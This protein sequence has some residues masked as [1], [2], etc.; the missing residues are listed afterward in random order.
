[1]NFSF[2]DGAPDAIASWACGRRSFEGPPQLHLRAMRFTDVPPTPTV[3]ASRALP[4][5]EAALF[6]V[7]TRAGLR[8]ISYPFENDGAVV[9]DVFPRQGEEE[10]LSSH[11]SVP[12]GYHTEMSFLDYSDAPSDEVY[13]CPEILVFV[14]LRN[15]A[16]TPMETVCITEL[17]RDLR[18]EDA[19]LLCRPIFLNH[20]PASIKEE[21]PATL[22]CVMQT[23]SI[24]SS[25]PAF[26]FDEC[27]T[28]STC[29]ESEKAVAGLRGAIQRTEK[30]VVALEPGD[31]F[32][33]DNR[34]VLHG[35]GAIT[36]SPKGQARWLKRIYTVFAEP[37]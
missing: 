15:Q 8:T 9:R 22:K 30:Q 17:I 11:G 10:T 34:S 7:I 18:P 23:R 25:V 29:G 28:A 26:Q 21:R 35:R 36:S 33:I 1:M 12:L 19:E 3:E 24:R 2:A 20:P 16:S 13:Q 27:N 4:S 5:L 31:I 37:S 32:L 6:D 14:C